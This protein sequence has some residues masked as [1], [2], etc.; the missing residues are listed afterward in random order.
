MGNS[1]ETPFT[2]KPRQEMHTFL[3]G[4]LTKQPTVILKGRV[5]LHSSFFIFS[6]FLC[7]LLLVSIKLWLCLYWSSH[8]INLIISHHKLLCLSCWAFH[9]LHSLPTSRIIHMFI[10]KNK[11][12]LLNLFSYYLKR[13]YIS[14]HSYK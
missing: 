11:L 4:M 2:T 5:T 9:P 8:I 7:H 6:C 14:P 10:S 12:F 1:G 13:I 3:A